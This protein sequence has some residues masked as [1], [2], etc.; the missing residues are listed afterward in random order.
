[1][2]APIVHAESLECSCVLLFNL[3]PADERL[4]NCY[5]L[6]FVS[7]TFDDPK[8]MPLSEDK[9]IRRENEGRKG[10]RWWGRTGVS[11]SD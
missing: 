3:R 8:A 2:T 7:R 5:I 11:S 10:G 6:L 1:M 9:V 4:S